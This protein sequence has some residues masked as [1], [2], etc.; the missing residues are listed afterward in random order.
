M[1]ENVSLGAVA[2]EGVE[3]VGGVG[4]AEVADGS[5]EEEAIVTFTSLVFIDFVSSADWVLGIE[6]V[7]VSVFHVVA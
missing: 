1:D 5:D 4:W 7:A 6:G 2:A 3:V